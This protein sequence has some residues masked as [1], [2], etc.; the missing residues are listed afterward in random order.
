MPYLYSPITVV[1]LSL[2][3]LTAGCNSGAAR[4]TPPG[5]DA[6]DSAEQAM[7]LYDTNADGV[8]AGDELEK[9]HSLR[10]A[11]KTIDTNGDGQ[12]SESEIADRILSWQASKAGLTVIT[13][14]V[15]LN[16]RP[17]PEATV[18]FEPEPFLGGEIQTAIGTTNYHGVAMPTIPKE[19]RPMSD[20]PPGIQLGFY[21]VRISKQANGQETIP[22]KYN[23]E[24]I[25]A[26]QVSSDD[27]AVLG[28][29]IVFNL[30]LK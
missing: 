12:I 7:E 3:L 2:L 25:L 4:I 16:G 21:K 5:I 23:S 27:P 22:A 28:R 18:T 13:C 26:Q 29:Q 8:I 17:L 10:A 1:S 20:M 11:M 19:K 30:T 15:K 9:A 14:L 24:T 6:S